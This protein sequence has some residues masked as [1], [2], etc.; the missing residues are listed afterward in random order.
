MYENK[1]V[2]DLR[3]GK[4]TKEQLYKFSICDMNCIVNNGLSAAF[5]EASKVKLRNSGG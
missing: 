3:N 2:R 5:E 1:I 4:A